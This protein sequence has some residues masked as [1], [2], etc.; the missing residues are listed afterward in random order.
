[1]SKPKQ[2]N[3][4]VLEVKE[5]SPTVKVVKFSTPKDFSF[6]AGQYIL[7][8]V[9]AKEGKKIRRAY[10]IASNPNVKG[11][12]EL[13]VK[14]IDNGLASNFICNLKEG[15]EVE[16]FGPAGRFVIEDNS[17]DKD[18]IFIA[19]G[20]GISPFV[21]MIPDLLENGFKNKITLIK[22]CRHKEDILYNELCND[23]KQNYSNFSTHVVLSRPNNLEDCDFKGY[24]QNCLP[25]VIPENFQGHV[26]ICGLSEM[27]NEVEK[28]L[29]S[30]GL[31]ED[32][33]FFEKYD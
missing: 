17:K 13:C 16:F 23:L 11:S 19:V 22:G 2:F 14:H 24:V 32:Q 29:K 1:M 30:L 31:K 21:A 26:Y 33:I 9:P 3:S 18:I 7:I 20:T 4:N 28:K 10:S 5:L 27:I 25:E 12:I 6:S 15:N 8:S